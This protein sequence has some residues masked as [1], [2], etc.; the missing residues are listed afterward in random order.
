MIARVWTA[1]ATRQGAI[2]YITFFRSYWLLKLPSFAGYRGVTAQTREISSVVEITLTTFWDSMEASLAF[3]S[4][5][6]E[7]RAKK[8]PDN[9]ATV[10]EGAAKCLIDYDPS[11]AHHEIAVD[12]FPIVAKP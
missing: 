1:R 4:S 8:T 3:G 5:G 12:C 6:S 11:V 7:T 10:P 9:C 2:D